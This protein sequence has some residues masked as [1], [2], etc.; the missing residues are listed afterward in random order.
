[1]KEYQL[2][3]RASLP[4]RKRGANFVPVQVNDE[5]IHSMAG[6]D[7]GQSRAKWR[8]RYLRTTRQ[9]TIDRPDSGRIFVENVLTGKRNEF[10]GILFGV[11]F[12]ES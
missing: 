10:Y 3:Q 1:M 9:P 2:S 6:L 4:V 8:Y 7:S 12:R 11:T 5:L